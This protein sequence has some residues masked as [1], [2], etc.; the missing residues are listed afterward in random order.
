[1]IAKLVRKVK[2]LLFLIC[3]GCLCYGASKL[4]RN[5]RVQEKLFSILGEDLYLALL[6][7]ARL[8]NDLL[9]WPVEYVRAL[10]P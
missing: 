8:L 6:E 5:E 4:L 7:K 2:Q 1:M 10:L 3:V 9:K